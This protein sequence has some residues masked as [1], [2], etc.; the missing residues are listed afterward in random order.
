MPEVSVII[1]VYNREAA[2]RAAAASVVAQTYHD[3]EIL[4]VDDG[5]DAPLAGFEDARVRVIR[6]NANKGAAAARNTGV[7]N[8]TG[9]WIAFLDSDDLWLPEKL[10]RQMER[11]QAGVVLCDA[12]FRTNGR[13]SVRALPQT[14]DWAALI[15]RGH[16][17]NL[18]SAALI[19][20]SVFERVGPFDEAMRRLEDWDWMLRAQE[21]GVDFT[22]VAQP[23]AIIQVGAPPSVQAVDDA[24]KRLE[25]KHRNRS[26]SFK[27]ALALERAAVRVWQK[28]LLGFLTH[29][30][31][32][33]AHAPVQATVFVVKRVMRVF[34]GDAPR[35][36]AL[37]EAR[38]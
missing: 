7:Q 8:A 26:A 20:K 35:L 31:R 14:P 34:K 4:V 29:W 17:F 6:H 9:L 23:L 5:S 24:V 13:D 15:D 10:E 36:F 25:E 38:Q 2:V 18:G 3:L 1:P 21:H 16:G 19:R 22:T 33:F 37:M 27:A 12:L 30:A 28:D 11:G 32:G